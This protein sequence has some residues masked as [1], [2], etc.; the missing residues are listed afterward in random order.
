LQAGM[1]VRKAVFDTVEIADRFRG[2]RELP[3]TKAQRV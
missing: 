2:L 1:D 3:G